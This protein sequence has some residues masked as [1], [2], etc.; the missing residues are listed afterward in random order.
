MSF[1]IHPAFKSIVGQD[2]AMEFLS[3]ALKANRFPHGL[4]FAGPEGV[5]RFK[6]A[7]TLA[8]IFLSENPDDLESIEKTSKQVSART[9]PDFHLVTRTLVREIEGK[10]DNKAIALSVD[11]IREFLV[12][13]AG[14]KSFTSRGK[15][16]IVDEADTMNSQAQNA[17]L[18]T[19]EEP[20][21]RTLIVLLTEQPG[22][23]LPTI[24]S[25][26]QLVQ[27][28]RLTNEQ[29]ME[30]VKRE[31]IEPSIAKLAVELAG[32]SP[33]RAIRYARDGV[34]LASQS[35][36]SLL[37]SDDPNRAESLAD[38]L[39]SSAEAL[40][41]KQLERD[42][43]GSKEGFTRDGVITYLALASN[44]LRRKIG[45]SDEDEQLCTR[46]D[47]IHQAENYLDGNVNL[48]LIVRQIGAKLT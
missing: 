28:N 29:A 39:K 33:G 15:V 30:I 47:A 9:H 34:A 3:R 42:P 31:G 7:S 2:R 44:H 46:I 45:S 22:A 36:F 48:P 27:F 6:T 24:R 37:D 16:F 23:L 20:S 13:P 40:A 32:G 21:G 38:F 10:K 25:R 26:S 8:S 4:I 14:R 12:A 5:G 11:V 43:Q 18:K 17:M 35:L 19:L 41:E 1:E